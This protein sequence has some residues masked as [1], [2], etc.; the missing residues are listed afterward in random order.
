MGARGLRGQKRGLREHFIRTLF[1]KEMVPAVF[2][3]KIM[4]VTPPQKKLFIKKC[5]FQMSHSVSLD[6][7][8]ECVFSA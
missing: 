2:Q 5:K 4:G 8:K 6:E 1:I 3:R 7:T